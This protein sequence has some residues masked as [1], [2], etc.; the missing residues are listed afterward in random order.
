M[1]KQQKEELN[2]VIKFGNTT[3]STKGL[4]GMTKDEFIAAHEGKIYVKGAL[5]VVGK[6]LKK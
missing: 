2:K 4:S 6:Y 1:A 5:K 3:F